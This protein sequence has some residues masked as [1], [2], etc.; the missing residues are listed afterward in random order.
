M[1]GMRRDGVT[2]IGEGRER[3]VSRAMAARRRL[4]RGPAA[5]RGAYVESERARAGGRLWVNGV[6]VGGTDPRHAA[7]GLSFD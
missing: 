7:L 3:R 5:V 1:D 4:D 6:E 2:R